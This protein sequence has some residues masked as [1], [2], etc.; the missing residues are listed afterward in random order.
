MKNYFEQYLSLSI[1]L[2]LIVL[3][4]PNPLLLFSQNIQFERIPNEL[5]L[6][7]NLIS[8]LCQDRQGFI[9]VGTKDGLNR[10]DGYHFRVFQHDP[11]DSTTISDNSV[12]CILEDSR[13]WLWVGTSD[14]LNLMHRETESFQRIS[15]TVRVV[16]AAPAIIENHPGLSGTDILSLM[17]D[18]E[19]NIWVGTMQGGVVKMEIPAGRFNPERVKYTVFQATAEENS[20][21][22]NPVKSM[23]E[24]EEGVVW[25]HTRSQICQIRRDKA[26]G[27]YEVKRLHWEDVD[28][29]WTGY[30]QEDFQYVDLGKTQPDHRFYS[31]FRDAAGAVWLTTAGGFAK[32][33]PRRKAF[34]LYPLEVR[35]ADYPVP[36][37]MGAE[38][39]D[40]F[41]DRKGR[42]WVDGLQTL[43]VYDTLSHHIISQF[44]NEAAGTPEFFRAGFQSIMQDVNG[45]IW[46]GTNGNGLYRY[47]PH[48]KRFSDQKDAMHWQGESLRA[49]HQTRDGTVWMGTASRK[50][51]RMDWK[52]KKTEP[53]V[54]NQSE[55]VRAFESEIDQVFAMDEDR[56]GNL[57]VAASR[58]LFR[59]RSEGGRLPDWKL[60]RIYE[61]EEL[62]PNV[63]DVHID[64]QGGIWLLTHFEFGRFD[65]VTGHFDGHDYLGISGGRKEMGSSFPCI[66]QQKNGLFWLGTKQGLLRFDAGTSRFTFFT[67]DP[68]NPNS[69]SHP[70]VKCISADPAEPERVLWIGT[71]GGGLNRFD[72]ET[73]QFSHFKK[74]DGLPDNVIYAI[75]S[76]EDGNLWMSTNQGLSKFNPGKGIFKNYGAEDGLQDNEFNSGAYFKSKDG[77]LFFGGIGG[78][79]AFLPSA[80]KN[81]TFQPPVVITDFKIANRSV[82]F[83]A[84]GSP[85]KESISQAKELV[86]TWRD[87]IFS[88]EFAALDFTG[89]D[90]NQ[91]AYKLENFDQDWQYIGTQRTATFTNLDP[92]DYVFRVKG[93]NHDGTWNETGATLKIIILP[94]W[95]K[96]WWAWLGYVLLLGAA[97][98]WFYKF[99]LNRKLEHAEAEKIKEMDVLKTRLYTNITHEFRTPLT[100][101]M[102]ANDQVE[103][104]IGKLRNWEI[105]KALPQNFSISNF[106]IFNNLIRRNSQNLLRLINQLLDLSK[107]DSGM[108]RPD[109]VQA[110]II[111]YLEYLTESF[112]SMAAEKNIRLVFYPEMRSLVM[113]FDEVKMQHIIYNLLSNALKFTEPGGKVVL[114]AKIR[115]EKR[116]VRSEKRDPS[117]LTP[118]LSL[119]VS[120]TGAGIPPESLPYIFDRFY[121][122][123]SSTTRRGEGT[124]I[125]LA[126]TKEL[127]EM[128]QGRISVESTPGEGTVFTV[129]LPVKNEAAQGKVQA[130]NLP[131]KQIVVTSPEYPAAEKPDANTVLIVEDNPD[132]T[133]Y[134]RQL[135]EKDYQIETAA[136]G[137]AGI[138][139]A[140]ELIPDIIISDVMMPKKD[141]FELTETLK[142]DPRTSHIPIVL[143]TARAADE[144]RIAG[145]KT[146][147]DAYLKKPFNKEELFIRLE[148]LI[149]LRRVLQER[150]T[151][152]SAGVSEGVTSSHTLTSSAEPTL[153]D[154]FIQKIRQTIDEKIDDSSLGVEH[155][156]EA[157]HLSNTQLF[158]K[159]KALTGESPYRFIQKI[160][161][162][163]AH[164]MLQATSLTISEIAY[165]LGFS[166]PNYFSRAFNKEF[167]VAPSDVRK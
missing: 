150:Y 65:P 95:W 154:L 59:F 58:G 153:D 46:V 86:L 67:N 117:L 64:G 40:G 4:L 57:W 100:V 33:Q 87:N 140:L 148:K 16:D 44:H 35:L 147:A 128:M 28:P 91:Y 126:L 79:N 106:S 27:H 108:L 80:V 124:G 75:L 131:E 143:L 72:T 81:D 145:L 146:G 127:V 43:V 49:I 70:L 14:G 132:V 22:K 50:L 96:T 6:S 99:Q 103:E 107:L 136:D 12:K 37:L 73:G 92:G 152:A 93:S 26:G 13:G 115:G 8:A 74:S 112:S 105:G 104:E 84:S 60:F 111:P 19:G 160:R 121:Q 109:Y 144:D 90:R 63:F 1:R 118:H 157:A 137:Q 119:L 167:G 62:Y 134:I 101:I 51:L 165:E 32:W 149:E 141:G 110:D 83:K 89:P 42:I 156:C 82:D 77:R 76:D 21:W 68:K 56:H 7:Q 66:F 10:F 163:R 97:A 161:L 5:G 54:L 88:F 3:F 125:G 69:L 11:F 159:M 52:S 55:W 38:G 31:I 122:V 17:E 2:L 102:G 23:A 130:V 94:P 15:P 18:R 98:Y 142:N 114:H 47:F 164:E 30:Q 45:N 34:A 138:E 158:R 61:G 25:V 113:D 135:L 116:D 24:D 53:L 85:L 166:D 71:G 162:H 48:K 36:P 123:D 120:D 20:L 78:F 39:V 129:V 155:L 151:R 139:K 133:L 9:W 41:L 29:Q